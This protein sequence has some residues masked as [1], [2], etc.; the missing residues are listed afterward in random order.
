MAVIWILPLLVGNAVI[1]KN[2][3][4]FYLAPLYW[5]YIPVTKDF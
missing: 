5:N 1:L 2:V 3:L 4:Q